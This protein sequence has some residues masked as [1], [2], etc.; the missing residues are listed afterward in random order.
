MANFIDLQPGAGWFNN[1][2]N[3]L[4]YIKGTHSTVTLTGINGWDASGVQ[5]EHVE[6]DWFNIWIAYGQ[7]TYKGTQTYSV[8]SNFEFAKNPGINAGGPQAWTHGFIFGKGVVGT[9]ADEGNGN[10]KAYI[11]SG[12]MGNMYHPQINLIQVWPK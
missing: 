5:I 11:I 10:F 7:L 8:G 3:N 2:K 4:N 6:N 9:F 1:L 12:S